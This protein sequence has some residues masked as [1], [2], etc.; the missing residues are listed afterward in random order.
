ML[1]EDAI[2]AAVKEIQVS[3]FLQCQAPQNGGF[4]EGGGCMQAEDVVKAAVKDI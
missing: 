4:R 2:K 3:I 1:A